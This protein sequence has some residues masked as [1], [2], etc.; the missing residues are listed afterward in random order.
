MKKYDYDLIVIGGGAAGL[1]ASTGAGQLGAKVLLVEKEDK[2][3][4]DCLHYGCVPSKT[5]I[6][7]AY[8]YNILKN[9][10]K[11]GLPR[12]DVPAADFRRIKER[13]ENTIRSIQVHDSPEWI[14]DKYNVDT[15]FEPAA[16][17]D[18]HT[19]RVGGDKFT[20]K[21]ILLA[22]GSSPALPPI[23][24]LQDV[25]YLTNVEIFSLERLP[26]SMIVL[27]AGPIGAEL[28]QA[29]ARLGTEVTMVEAAGQVLPQ[30]DED[31]AG[32]VRKRLEQ[33]GVKILLKTKAVRAGTGEKGIELTLDRDGTSGT[34]QAQTLLVATGRKA[35]VDG[36]G[37]DKAGV[38]YT[39]RAV[40]VDSRLRTSTKHVFAAGDVTGGY[41]FTHVAGYE[42]GIAMINAVMR[43][44][45]KV[46][47]GQIPW[48]TYL[49][50]E[51]ASIGFNEKRARE[52]GRQYTLH[53][54]D[55]RNNDRALAE[56]EAGGFIKLLVG[57]KGVPIGV[58]IVGFHA[59]DLIHEWVAAING[60]VPL[61]T[62]AQSVHIYPTM[63]EINK[64]V[65]GNY[66]APQLFNDFVRKLL[67]FSFGLQGRTRF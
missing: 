54:E 47:Y 26:E 1:T 29:F 15:V 50:P 6:K 48:C 65:S 34:V 62:L 67:K 44:P 23:E 16:F 2:L 35:N 22:T 27:G 66:L 43:L 33:D 36:L 64:I 45:V 19:V 46:D 32:L 25:P 58:Q 30:E 4:G 7:S 59:G 10:E 9:A 14:K 37:L 61:S 57:K 63:S 8:C 53:K 13:I 18:P 12:V 41:Q 17:V 5:L 56:G 21:N 49:D 28:A 40:Q 3:G 38:Q 11:Y 24:G 20:A 55:F 51:V 39:P 42:A 31:V 52:A 60:K